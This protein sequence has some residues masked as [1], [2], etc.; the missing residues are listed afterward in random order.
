MPVVQQKTYVCAYV[1]IH[2]EC[3]QIEA[4][5][6]D[7]GKVV[8]LHDEDEVKPLH[9][10]ENGVPWTQAAFETAWQREITYGQVIAANPKPADVEAA[11][12]EGK[13]RQGRRHEAA[14]RYYAKEVQRL[15][16]A[17]NAMKKLETGWAAMR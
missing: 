1:Q 4:A 3:R 11:A 6:P 17:I 8:A 5:R 16:L 10:Y 14:V 13:P 2:S 7:E 12:W 9:V 15:H